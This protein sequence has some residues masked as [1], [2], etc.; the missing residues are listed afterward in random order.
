MYSLFLSHFFMTD[1]VMPIPVGAL[2]SQCTGGD[3]SK[4]P[5]VAGLTPSC[6]GCCGGGLT[7]SG[8]GL[9]R[10]CSTD[11]SGLPLV[12]FN[13]LCRFFDYIYV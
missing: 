12:K 9:P 5:T 13:Y 11:V 3:G 1:G 6:L 4:D 7:E 10:I 8:E 2:P